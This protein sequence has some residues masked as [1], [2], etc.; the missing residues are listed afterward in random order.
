MADCA[1]LEAE[2]ATPEVECKNVT[3][4]L[5]PNGNAIL[6]PADVL[7]AEYQLCGNRV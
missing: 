2:T 3:V 5:D 7:K 1:A 4:T 6:N